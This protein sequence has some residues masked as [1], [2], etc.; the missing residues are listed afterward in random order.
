[1]IGFP[2]Q[3]TDF[4][5]AFYKDKAWEKSFDK[6]IKS[7]LDSSYLTK[8]KKEDWRFFPFHKVLFSD[9]DF[10]SKLI[11][12]ENKKAQLKDSILIQIKNGRPLPCENKAFQL[13]SWEDF[14]EGKVSLSPAVQ[15]KVLFSL[16][17][18]R[19]HFSSLNNTFYPKGFL[20][21]FKDYI[22]QPVEIHYTQDSFAPQQGL[23][24]RNFIFVEKSVQV[25][26]FFYERTSQQ[27]LFLNVQ[28][29]CFLEETAHL[30]YFSFDNMAEQDV[31][32]HQMFTYL[33]KKSK[34]YFLNLSLN[35]GLSRWFKYVE[36]KQESE[37]KIKALSL[38]SGKTHTD[39]KTTVKHKGLRGQSEQFFK[40]FLFDSARYIFQ[41]LIAIEK[42]ADESDTSQLNK[43]YLF[44]PKTSAVSFPELDIYPANVKAEHGSTTSSF[45][46]NNQLLFYLRSRGIDS[47]ES[48][49]LA[50]LSLLEEIFLDCSKNIH[51]LIRQR[52][53]ER[54]PSLEQSVNKE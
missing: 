22:K 37:S 27:P 34:A 20:L 12:V 45:F 54:L 26:E 17:K 47:S 30:E 3:L 28:T 31:V 9:F 48:F 43:N 38:M 21:V 14:L 51:T 32:I 13:L 11:E 19:N 16:N 42:S 1:M 6:Q 41:G 50:L 44:S 53:E 52:I 25:L 29:D 36:Q 33:N 5:T 8:E 46:E 39:Y 35:A 10:Y 18:E 2:K 15:D 7:Y 23:N 49:H 40:S 24:L 4:N